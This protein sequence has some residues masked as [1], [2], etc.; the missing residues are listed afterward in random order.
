MF[1]GQR[2]SPGQ[3]LA[4]G[5]PTV[6]EQQISTEVYQKLENKLQRLE[7]KITQAEC[8]ITK[9]TTDLDDEKEE[10]FKIVK[11]LVQKKKE[12]EDEYINSVAVVR[13]QQRDIE[14]KTEKIKVLE[15]LKEADEKWRNRRSRTVLR[16]TILKKSGVK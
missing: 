14:E 7:L 8:T 1:P 5:Q 10:K 2:A 6:S 4:P 15:S 9:L 3:P 13:T 11:K 16:R 12:I